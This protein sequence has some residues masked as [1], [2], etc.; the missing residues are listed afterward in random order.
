MLARWR[1]GRRWVVVRVVFGGGVGAGEVPKIK[2]G[3]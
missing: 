1:R 2:S 3:L